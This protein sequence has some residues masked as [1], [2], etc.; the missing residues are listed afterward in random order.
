[1]HSAI[2][3]LSQ[4]PWDVRTAMFKGQ[5]YFCGKDV[6]RALGYSEPKSAVRNHLSPDDY[7][8]LRYIA[9]PSEQKDGV[10]FFGL[11]K[12]LTIHGVKKL[13]QKSRKPEAMKLAQQ[14]GFSIETKYLMKEQ[15]IVKHVCDFLH[16][17]HIVTEFQKSVGRY[18]IDLYL[19]DYKI[20]M[21]IDE[22]GHRDRDLH[23]EKCRED[24]LKRALGC[25]FYRI[26]PDDENFNIFKMCGQL[27]SMI[28]ENSA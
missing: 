14:L 6:A 1:M 16:E 13:V 26:N 19:P 23:N 25:N 17:L 24:F 3:T 15:E 5:P 8:E 7:M 27:A 10:R 18:R 11:T 21:E 22:H 20:A 12:Y 28:M 9:A 4:K 2:L